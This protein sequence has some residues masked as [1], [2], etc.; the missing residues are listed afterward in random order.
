[1]MKLSTLLM[2]VAIS[3]GVS[4]AIAQEKGA[5]AE[6]YPHISGNVIFRLGYDGDYDADAPRIESNDVFLDMIASPEIHFTKRFSI[7]SEIRIETARPPTRDRYFEEQTLFVRSLFMKYAANDNLSLHAGKF[8]PS[9]SFA[10]FEIPGM[11]GNSYNR[12]IELIE[13]VGFGAEYTFNAGASGRHTLSASTFF[14]DTSILSDSLALGSLSRGRNRLEDGGASNTESFES[15][16]VSLE[17]SDISRLPG[18]TYKLAYLHEAAGRGDVADED[19][20][21]V[22]AMQSFQLGDGKSLT[23]IGEVAPLWNFEGS[24]DNIIYTSAGLVYRANPWLAILSG[25]SRS[26]DLAS[27]GTFE[28][29]TVQISVEYDLGHGT[30]IALAHEFTRDRN[31]NA[32]LFGFRLN[33]VLNFN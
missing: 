24:A 31:V 4:P 2:C 27:G 10:S 21:L 7:D 12:E 20:F 29:Y 5:D 6:T 11:Y 22:A 18:F 3:L 8:T 16:A 19:G 15:F 13:R 33:Q 14:D 1:M 9:F 26:R 28:D 32:R 30:S 23:L 25:T 17:G